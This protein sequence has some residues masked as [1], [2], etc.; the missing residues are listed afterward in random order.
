MTEYMTQT[1]LD[2]IAW[3]AENPELFFGIVVLSL[4]FVACVS[5]YW[6]LTYR[7]RKINAAHVARERKVARR[8]IRESGGL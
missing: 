4:I 8:K 2:Y 1:E 5:A 6:Y 3:R 7:E